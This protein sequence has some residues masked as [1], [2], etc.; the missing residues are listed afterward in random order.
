MDDLDA[1]LEL[2]G[3]AFEEDKGVFEDDDVGPGKP[4]EE[5]GER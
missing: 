1:L 2:E 5:E 3:A 4:G